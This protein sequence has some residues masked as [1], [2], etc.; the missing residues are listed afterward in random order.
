MLKVRLSFLVGT[1]CT[2]KKMAYLS[3][4]RTDTTKMPFFAA[5]SRVDF[6]P[7]FQMTWVTSLENL[8]DT[9]G[10]KDTREKMMW[11]G[12]DI[13]LSDDTYM[14]KRLRMTLFFILLCDTV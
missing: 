6:L 10:Q 8:G 12:G 9:L 13:V 7:S 1:I 14:Y 3:T 2:D 5:L 11:K 4:Q